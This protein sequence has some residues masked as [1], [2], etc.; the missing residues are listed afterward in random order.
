MKGFAINRNNLDKIFMDLDYEN[1]NKLSFKNFRQALLIKSGE[2]TPDY[3]LNR[4]YQ[5]IKG[6]G[7]TMEQLFK[8]EDQPM[9]E[10]GAEPKKTEAT[11]TKGRKSAE[12]GMK[13]KEF[14]K[15]FKKYKLDIDIVDLETLFLVVDKDQSGDLSKAE[16]FEA[17]KKFDSDKKLNLNSLI[18]VRF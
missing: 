16:L 1:D 3:I 6:Q 17:F 7:V 8:I 5:E 2:S 10:L 9:E 14:V 13:F 12:D 4:I 15:V 11:L 18:L